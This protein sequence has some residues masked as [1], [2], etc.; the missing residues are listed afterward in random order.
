MTTQDD[1][2]PST[3]TSAPSAPSTPTTRSTDDPD[4]LRDGITFFEGTIAKVTKDGD[5]VLSDHIGPG[6]KRHADPNA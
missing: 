5:V 1:P 3:A 2:I 6:E 4:N